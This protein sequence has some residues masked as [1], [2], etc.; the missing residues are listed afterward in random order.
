MTASVDSRQPA[1]AHPNGDAALL[2]SRAPAKLPT[3]TLPTVGLSAHPQAS[4]AARRSLGKGELLYLQGDSA[5]T[6]FFV[7]SGL[8]KLSIVA[9]PG[10]ERIVGLA[11]PG[12][13]IGAHT[14][15]QS[16]FLDS[17]SALSQ[18]VTVV[19]LD[20][21][22]SPHAELGAEIRYL[23]GEAAYRHLERL[24][25]Q[26]EDAEVPVPARVA[27]TFLRLAERFG[28]DGFESNSYESNSY[29]SYQAGDN[30]GRGAVR[31]TL[32]LTH[33]TLAA[34]VGAARETT[35][36]TVEQLRRLGLVTGTRG[37]YVVQT[38]ALQ[39][40]ASQAAFG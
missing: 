20:V 24:T 39:A 13:L 27:R 28:Q 31:L 23:L 1:L 32:P 17:A 7:E 21:G 16:R 8:L 26:L 22:G 14:Q 15:G 3:G 25:H 35:S 36:T 33:D 2:T 5:T 30:P 6:A 34:M 4:G 9:R 19:K 40:F 10:R 29:E 38:Q 12:D 18:D 11:G 37:R